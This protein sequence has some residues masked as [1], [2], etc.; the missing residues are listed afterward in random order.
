MEHFKNQLWLIIGS[1]QLSPELKANV[2]FAV[3]RILLDPY[4]LTE[5]EC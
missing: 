4:N 1:Y 3:F 5:S 2:V